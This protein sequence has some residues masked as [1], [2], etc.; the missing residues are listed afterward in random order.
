MEVHQLD[1]M[2]AGVCQDEH[3]M[4]S[5]ISTGAPCYA[6]TPERPV[7][8]LGCGTRPRE[9]ALNVDCVALR[10]VDVVWDLNTY[11]WPFAS[12]AWRRVLAYHVLE[13]LDD[14]VRATAEIHR[15]LAPG[16]VAEVRV[17]HMGGCGA[18]NNPTHR[19]FFT[20]HSF[21]YFKRGHH[22]SY[23]FDFAF[24][25]VRCRNVFGVGRSARLNELMNPLVNTRFYDRWLWKLVPCAEVRVTLVK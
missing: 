23:Y 22:Y 6:P 25:D 3:E 9:K 1:E 16:G 18:W 5:S 13:H 2:I 8:H 14:A 21:D 10:G 20:R 17:P 24:S 4:E 19:H 11:P 7:L 15:I 12:G